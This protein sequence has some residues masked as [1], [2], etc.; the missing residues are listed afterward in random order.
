MLLLTL[1]ACLLAQDATFKTA[2]SM[3]E[4]DAQVSAR[5]ASSKGCKWAISPSRTIGN[6]CGFVTPARKKH[7]SI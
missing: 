2:V 1:A 7:P 4:V 6:R 5:Q 3:V